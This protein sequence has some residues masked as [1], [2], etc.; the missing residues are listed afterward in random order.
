[1]ECKRDAY[2]KWS[3]MPFRTSF[4]SSFLSSS[5]GFFAKYFSHLKANHKKRQVAPQRKDKQ[6]PSE[7]TSAKH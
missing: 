1:M 4:F 6:Q 5:E 2:L 7:S 3:G